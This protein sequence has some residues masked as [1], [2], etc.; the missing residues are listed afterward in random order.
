M[1]TKKGDMVIWI[2]KYRI[3]AVVEHRQVYSIKPSSH[4]VNY[5]YE[6]ITA[7]KSAYKRI[8]EVCN[9][10]AEQQTK[11]MQRIEGASGQ[12]TLESVIELIS[13]SL[14]EYEKTWAPGKA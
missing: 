11:R 12:Q 3:D 10:V 13:S 4:S 1:K 14:E 6:Y 5:K 2:I 8:V 7:P 9:K